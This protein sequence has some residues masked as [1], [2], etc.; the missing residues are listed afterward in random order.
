M[1]VGSIYAMQLVIVT[2]RLPPTS[3]EK[4]LVVT[5]FE[6]MSMPKGVLYPTVPSEAAP[7]QP[8]LYS[9]RNANEESAR[10]SMPAHPS[11][12]PFI[13]HLERS[14]MSSKIFFSMPF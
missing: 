5:S 7:R 6:L 12:F 1:F 2:C 11:C 13:R 3:I 9:K 14:R 4:T 10:C 8:V